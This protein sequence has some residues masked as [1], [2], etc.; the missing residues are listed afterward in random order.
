[1]EYLRKITLDLYNDRGKRPAIYAKQGDTGRVL[2]VTLTKD[3]IVFKPEDGVTAGIRV[4][5]PD[6]HSVIDPATINEDGTITAALTGQALACAGRCDADIYLDKDGVVLSNAVFDL[7]VQAAPIG[8]GL[9]S[10][11][12]FLEMV[13][14]R[15]NA[16]EAAAD[17]R[18]AAQEANDAAANADGS[19]EAANEAEVKRAAAEAERVEAENERVQAETQRDT[20]EQG[21]ADAEAERVQAE[22]DREA[23]EQGRADAETQREQNET[24]RQAAETDREAAEQGR[25]DAETDREAAEKER[26]EAEAGRVEAEA[27]RVQEHDT[28][29]QEAKDATDA[30]NDAAAAAAGAADLATHPPIIKEGTWWLWNI[31]AQEYQDTGESARG[32]VLFATFFVDH[33]D[34]ILYMNTDTEY[35]GPDFRLTE[36]GILEVV[37]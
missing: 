14:E 34:G 11:N 23:A 17:A 37:I 33:T 8:D 22:T 16:Q 2:L 10:S 25:V 24:D 3:G 36:N 35:N 20:A 4:K 28:I 5:K 9:T 12:E 27:E 18:Q 15:K 32:N 31:E 13:E 1:M 30:A 7:L 21:R 6:G 26:A 19:S 29:V